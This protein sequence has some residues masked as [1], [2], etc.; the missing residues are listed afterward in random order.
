MRQVLLTVP[1]AERDGQPHLLFD[2]FADHRLPSFSGSENFH[3]SVC[4]VALRRTSPSFRRRRDVMRF[5]R[6]AVACAVLF[7]ALTGSAQTTRTWATTNG[8]WTNGTNW[9]GGVAPQPG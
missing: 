7:V 1:G 6:I 8:N 2:T 5:F 4:S 9:V 3:N